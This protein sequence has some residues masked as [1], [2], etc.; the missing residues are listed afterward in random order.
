MRTYA[1]RLMALLLA[2]C[3]ALALAACGEDGDGDTTQLSGTVYV[4]EFVDIDLGLEWID[5]GCSDGTNLYVMGSLEETREETDPET[6]ESYTNYDYRTVI[7]RVSL[8]SGEAAELENYRMPQLDEGVEGGTYINNLQAGADGTLWITEY[9]YTY[10]YD[11]PE[12]FDPENDDKWNYQSDY[13]ETSVM[14]QLDSTG[15]EITHID[16]GD[17]PEKLEVDYVNRMAF[18]SDGNIYV[19][20]DNKI[21]ALDQEFNVLFSVEGEDLWRNLLTLGDGN[22]GIIVNYSDPENNIYGTKLMTIDREAQAWGPEYILPQNTDDGYSGGGEYLF[23]YQSGESVYGFKAGA[24]SGEK[25]FSWI[26]ADINRSNVEFFDFLSDGRVVAM[27]RNWNSSDRKTELVLLTAADASTLSE[28]TVLTYATMGLNYSDRNEIIQF[29]KTNPDYRIEVRDYSEFNTG[30][31]TSAG[32]TKLNTEIMAGNV[33]DILNASGLPLKQYGAKGMLEDLWPFIENDAEIGGREG[34]MEQVFRAAEQEGKLYEVFDSFVIQTVVG[35][36]SVVGDQMSWSLAELQSALDMM[37][38]GCAIFGQSDTKDG[39]LSQVLA[40]NMDSFVDW[41]TGQCSFDSDTFKSL[42]AFCNSFPAE[43]D[44]ESID[45]E[46]GEYEDEYTRILS[47]KQMLITAYLYDFECIQMYKTLFGGEVSFIG[48][49]MEDGSVGSSFS[50]YNGLAMS[51]TC[52]AKEGAWAYIRQLLLPDEEAEDDEYYYYGNFPTNK[53]S[54][55]KMVQWY[56]TPRY[57]E[58]ENGEQ[59]LDEN[60]EPIMVRRDNWWLS[61][62]LELDYYYTTQE[63]YDQIMELY[64]AIDTIYSFDENIYNIVSEVAGSYFSGDRSLD[65]TANQI[66]SRVKLYVNESR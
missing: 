51:S 36:A 11:L 47:G 25:L 19:S 34:V 8:E 65:D 56:M 7:L 62:D 17:L 49:P 9:T 10:T 12:D 33:P 20:T 61:N 60:G 27:T 55:D 22:I 37:P 39:I 38:E 31:D 53:S 59:I 52:K 64:N 4:P 45:W 58:D 13:Q 30:E 29:N 46:A 26:D 15:N 16:M 48:Y 35:P 28:R 66:Q 3:M 57:E 18:D 63:E 41:T 44:W 23:Y 1:K 6:G 21:F 42:L 32:L 43:F 14:R 2:M 5:G 40:Q 24:E 50:Y 54:F